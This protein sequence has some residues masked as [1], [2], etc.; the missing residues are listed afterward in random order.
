MIKLHGAPLS[1]YY[2]MAKT[3]LLEKS[4]DFEEVLT[5][6]SQKPEYL[7]HS[8]MGKIPCLETDN[9][10]VSESAAILEYIDAI[11]PE[12]PLFRAD[13]WDAAK[14]RELMQALP[15]YIELPARRGYGALRGQDVA[16][17]IKDEIGVRR[18]R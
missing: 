5:P 9:G 10:F 3:G 1:N 8:P 17:E 18:R 15:L 12:P 6:P 14:V 7:A 4:L 2:N 16:P 13:P 11:S